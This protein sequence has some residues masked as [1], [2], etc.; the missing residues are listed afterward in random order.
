[1]STK[2][3][4]VLTLDRVKVVPQ[5]LWASLLYDSNIRSQMKAAGKGAI[6]EG[7]NSTTIRQLCVK[8]PPLALQTRFAQLCEKAKRESEAV[9]ANL[10]MLDALFKSLQSAA[11]DGILFTDPGA[12][13][14]PRAV[15]A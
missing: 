6:M 12:A 3:L 2:H 7:W 15:A 10:L 14:K 13:M 8:V 9:H 1:M 4:C 11:F 5:F